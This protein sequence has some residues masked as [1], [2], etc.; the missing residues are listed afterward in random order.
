M[1]TTREGIPREAHWNTNRA[2]RPERA[3][4]TAYDLDGARDIGLEV[5]RPSEEYQGALVYAR[6]EVEWIRGLVPV[7]DAC[8]SSEIDG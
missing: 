6:S 5:V 7:P 2:Q 3:H 4:P 8:L 1:I